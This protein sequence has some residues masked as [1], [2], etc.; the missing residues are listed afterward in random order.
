MNLWLGFQNRCYAAVTQGH[1]M[2][3][4]PNLWILQCP[5]VIACKQNAQL[6]PTLRTP[7]LLAV[8]HSSFQPTH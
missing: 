6:A 3:H 5:V 4:L 7:D 1:A 8:D 2:P